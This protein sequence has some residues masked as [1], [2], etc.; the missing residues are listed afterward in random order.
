ME[1][2]NEVVNFTLKAINSRSSLKR[3]GELEGGEAGVDML[4][5]WSA[6]RNADPS[7]MST[8]DVIV[9][10]SGN[11]FAGSDTTAIVLRAVIYFLCKNPEAMTK[12][13]DELDAADRGG[14]LSNP[15]A[16]KEALNHLPYFNAVLKEAMR[17]HPS[18]GLLLERHVPSGGATLCGQHIPA[19][20]IIG[21]N[22]WV[23]HYD[24]KV[25]PKPEKFMPER[26]LDSDERKVAEM[27]RSFF[28]F[29]AGSRTCIGKNISLMEMAKIIPQLL[30]EYK[31]AL[32]HPKKEWKTK[33]VWFVQQSGVDCVLTRR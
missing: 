23:L 26:W 33:N 27:E 20:T 30:R 12:V 3:D 15:V 2:W 25:F 19:K 7:K 31:I 17:I 29:G 18:V 10:L 9:H 6:M 1:Q 4:S 8:R 24:E 28:A 16:Y 13:V 32:A 5:K 21:I 11:V 14:L 22:A